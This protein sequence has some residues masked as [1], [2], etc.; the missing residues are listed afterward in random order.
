MPAKGLSLYF[1]FVNRLPLVESDVFA[2][3]LINGDLQQ[4]TLKPGATLRPG[5]RHEIKLWGVG[6]NFSKAFGMPNA[7]LVAEGLEP[8]TIAETRPVIDPETGLE[9]LP[10][11]APMTDEAKLATKSNAD[12]TRWL[13]AERAFALQAGRLAPEAQ[14]GVILPKPAKAVQG[15]GQPADLTRGV[16]LALTGVERGAVDRKSTRLNS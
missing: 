7:Y 9:T 12:K 15:K 3:R 10:F 8:R 14:G 4:L 2:H 13:T 16:A 11:V 6:S 1:S 5:A